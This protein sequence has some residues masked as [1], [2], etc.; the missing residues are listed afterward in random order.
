VA[1]SLEF[2][3]NTQSK[4]TAVQ[5]VII[6]PEKRMD[7]RNVS[8]YKISMVSVNKLFEEGVLNEK[9]YRKIESELA[10]K[11]CIKDGSVYRLNNLNIIQVRANIVMKESEENDGNSSDPIVTKI[12]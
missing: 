7:K 5:I 6:V 11:Y 3:Q 9:Q 1:K 2:R 8:K 4:N 10:K 12:S